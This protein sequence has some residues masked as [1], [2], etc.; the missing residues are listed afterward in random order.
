MHFF[1]IIVLILAAK[2]AHAVLLCWH[3]ADPATFLGSNWDLIFLRE[4][5][6][7]WKNRYFWVCIITSLLF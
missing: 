4:Q 2:G 7:L 3:V 5:P 1:I 6:R